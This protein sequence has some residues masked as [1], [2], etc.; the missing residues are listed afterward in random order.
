MKINSIQQQ[1]FRGSLSDKL[2]NAIVKHP[3]LLTGITALAGCSVVSQKLVMSA[4]ETTIAPVVDIGVGKTITKLTDEKDGRT[5]QSSKIQ[6][7]RTIAQTVGGTITGIIIRVGCITAA[8]ALCMKAGKKAGSKIADIL[9]ETSFGK[10][11]VE[12]AEDLYKYHKNIEQ[13]GKNIG[14]AAATCVMMVTNFLIDAPLI[15]WINKKISPIF[16]VKTE[17]QPNVKEGK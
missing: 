5:N 14:G 17:E 9:T 3:K 12:K 13:W 10:I 16:G 11:N 7:V 8:T 1:N 2:A 6:A 15:N 4:A